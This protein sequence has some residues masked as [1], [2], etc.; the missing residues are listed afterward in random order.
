MT[1]S[2]D[3]ELN[4]R[5]NQYI[6]NSYKT[7]NYDININY[8][9][10]SFKDYDKIKVISSDNIEMYMDYKVALQSNTLSLFLDQ[11]LGYFNGEIKLPIIS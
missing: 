5:Y 4:N 1:L 6:L 2:K 9:D 11:K 3:Q 10:H 8:N 7:K